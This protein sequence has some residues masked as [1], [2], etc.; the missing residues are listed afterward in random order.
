MGIL[1]KSLLNRVMSHPAKSVI[2]IFSMTLGVMLIT[3]CFN[4]NVKLDKMVKDKD[5]T[6]TINIVSGTREDEYNIDKDWKD[7]YTLEILETLKRDFKEIKEITGFNDVWGNFIYN[8]D[9]FESRFTTRGDNNFL[10]VLDLE[11]TQGSSFEAGEERKAL[12][13]SDTK[14]VLFGSKTPLGEDIFKIDEE[15]DD[16]SKIG[17][18]LTPFEIIGVFKSPSSYEKMKIGV[19]EIIFSG[20]EDW[21]YN[22]L[23]IKTTT[24]NPKELFTRIE[25]VLKNEMGEDRNFTYW[26]GNIKEPFSET[27]WINETVTMFKIFFSILAG[28]SIL[29][30]A[31][32]VFS[33]TMI[34]VVERTR[35]IGLKRALGSNKPLI[36]SMLVIESAFLVLIGA[37]PGVILAY[38]FSEP[39]ANSV[40]PSITPEIDLTKG[41]YLGLEPQAILWGVLAIVSSGAILGIFPSLTAVNSHPIESIKDQ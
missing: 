40:F 28:V 11:I 39:F 16:R 10:K 29:I 35:E 22:Q 8:D 34:S 2:T 12:I 26:E 23:V 15:W 27:R 37:I 38:I 14:E 20:Q 32:G 25:R 31:F 1:L 21:V 9:R 13:S 33:V 24:D 41:L 6:T 17:E 36:V 7:L 4:I 3:L 30:S 18:E 19:P 5:S